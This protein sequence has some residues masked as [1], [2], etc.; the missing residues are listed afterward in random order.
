[1]CCHQCA[2]IHRSL[3]LAFV[4]SLEL[5]TIN[6]LELR[7]MESCGGNERANK[8]WQAQSQSG[9]KA[10]VP[11]SDMKERKRWIEAK[12]T[13]SGFTKPSDETR[14]KW[15]ENLKNA[16]SKGDIFVVLEC[17]ARR[18]HVIRDK[19]TSS[20]DTAIEAALQVSRDG[21]HILCERLLGMYQ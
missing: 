21:G 17:L 2:G 9:W 11:S 16:A 5:D 13:W 4:R 15:C 3:E 12:Y 14:V 20:A 18:R 1:M 8:I 19:E 6:A 7:M 10:P